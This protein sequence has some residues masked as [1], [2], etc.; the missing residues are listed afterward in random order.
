M[1]TSFS[2]HLSLFSLSFRSLLFTHFGGTQE[3]DFFMDIHT[4]LHLINTVKYSVKLDSRKIP[5]KQIILYLSFMIRKLNFSCFSVCFLRPA[6]GL[7]IFCI[8]YNLFDIIYIVL[9]NMECVIQ[10][11]TIIS[12]HTA[13]L[14]CS[15]AK[16]VF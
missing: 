13:T 9:Y 16:F 6:F 10:Y 12:T 14:Y 7:Y 5:C 8:L 4:A 11:S 15:F 2:L 3:A 1:F